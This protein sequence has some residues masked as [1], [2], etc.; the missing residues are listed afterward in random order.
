MAAK[1]PEGWTL[2]KSTD[3]PTYHSEVERSSSRDAFFGGEFHGRVYRREFREPVMSKHGN[4]AVAHH[5]YKRWVYRTASGKECIGVYRSMSDAVNGLDWLRQ[6]N[7]VKRADA[8]GLT[9]VEA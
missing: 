8:L 6:Q 9:E 5:V 3:L 2:K 4:Y 7:E 1:L